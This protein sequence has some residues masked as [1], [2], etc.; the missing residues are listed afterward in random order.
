MT[1][2]NWIVLITVLAGVAA[3]GITTWMT[4]R[5]K[6]AIVATQLEAVTSRLTAIEINHLPT[7][8]TTVQ[9]HMEE[10]V[11]LTER[12]KSAVDRLERLERRLNGG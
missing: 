11:K 10:I 7:L 5:V 4:F 12:M 9:E 6:L 1:V 8:T 3:S 2:G